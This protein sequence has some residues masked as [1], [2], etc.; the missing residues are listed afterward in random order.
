MA[1]NNIHSLFVKSV[2]HINM[3]E[4][5]GL[6]CKTR[7]GDVKGTVLS[8]GANAWLGMRSWRYLAFVILKC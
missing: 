7:F 4:N 3:V 8:T 1:N 5:Q 2:R 6:V